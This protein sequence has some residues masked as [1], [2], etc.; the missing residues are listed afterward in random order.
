MITAVNFASS[1][2]QSS[3]KGERSRLHSSM[4]SVSATLHEEPGKGEIWWLPSW[5]KLFS[6]E[7]GELIHIIQVQV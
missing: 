2:G 6:V 3:P 1:N 5:E 4:T 7:R